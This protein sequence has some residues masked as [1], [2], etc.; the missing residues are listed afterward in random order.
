MKKKIIFFSCVSIL[1]VILGGWIIRKSNEPLKLLK[2]TEKFYKENPTNYLFDGV[3]NILPYLSKDDIGSI[4]VTKEGKI[5]LRLNYSNKCY[6][7]D[8]EDKKIFH[9]LDQSQCFSYAINYRETTSMYS[10]NNDSLSSSKELIS[11]LKELKVKSLYQNISSEDL[12]KKY[13]E[14]VIAN[15]T[16]E[17]I[18]VYRLIGDA[19]WAFDT[20]IPKKLIK[21]IILYNETVNDDGKL[22]GVVLDIEPHLSDIWAHSEDKNELFKEYT[23]NMIDLYN[24]AKNGN[25]EV[26][27]CTNNWFSKFDYFDELY[28]KAA[29][30]YSIMNYDKRYN[31]DNLEEELAIASENHKKIE[32]IAH[33]SM[34]SEP[35][36]SY[37]NF[38]E[39]NKD[40]IKILKAYPYE[41]F[42][43]SYHY[44]PTITYL[45][46]GTVYLSVYFSSLE[47]LPSE[48][49][50]I[51]SNGDVQKGTL[52]TL[53]SESYFLFS[54]VNEKEDYTLS[55]SDGFIQNVNI[56]GKNGHSKIVVD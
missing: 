36:E 16:K 49:F 13:I 28:N 11:N 55:S 22:K 34:N 9:T 30:V 19:K 51:S 6:Y 48:L 25:L 8:F 10:W 44:L 33:S 20:S 2:A 32:T 21:E 45:K 54:N 46:N 4:V 17:K 27:L 38:A 56:E 35:E 23:L 14:D 40:H 3:T 12:D 42:R 24:Y 37:D 41:R 26:V 18:D 7:K 5:S 47:N 53:A 31:I 52:I 43:A 29:D 1:V 15:Y 39:L 50:L